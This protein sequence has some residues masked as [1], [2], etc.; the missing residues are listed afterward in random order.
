MGL[1]ANLKLLRAMKD[2]TIFTGLKEE[3]EE[4]ERAE[5][6]AWRGVITPARCLYYDPL[7]R[8]T[9]KDR[10]Y[11]EISSGLGLDKD[12]VDTNPPPPRRKLELRQNPKGQLVGRV[13][14]C[15]PP[16]MEA[17][18]DQLHRRLT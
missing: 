14:Y 2:R 11:F 15:P 18:G 1:G 3:R 6:R 4:G 16:L 12:S 13:I 10:G 5:P 17:S 7:L 9:E 8:L